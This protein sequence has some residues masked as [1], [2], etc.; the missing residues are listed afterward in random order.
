MG[1]CCLCYSEVVTTVSR[2]I[3]WS[4]WIAKDDAPAVGLLRVQQNSLD[5]M[6]DNVWVHVQHC[7]GRLHSLGSCQAAC[8]WMLAGPAV[9]EADTLVL[10]MGDVSEHIASVTRRRR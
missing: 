6:M 4:T 3:P 1:G 8:A 9:G 5:L 7:L 2:D 10:T